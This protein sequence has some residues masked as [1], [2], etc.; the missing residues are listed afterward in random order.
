MGYIK[1]YINAEINNY[2][3]DLLSAVIL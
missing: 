1:I 2:S 3:N